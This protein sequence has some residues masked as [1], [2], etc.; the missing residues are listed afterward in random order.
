MFCFHLQIISLIERL[1]DCNMKIRQFLYVSKATSFLTELEKLIDLF[2]EHLTVNTLKEQE[3]QK[4]VPPL[5][6]ENQTGKFKDLEPFTY[7]VQLLTRE[8]LGH[9]DYLDCHSEIQLIV[10]HNVPEICNVTPSSSNQQLSNAEDQTGEESVLWNYGSMV[11]K[12]YSAEISNAIQ[13]LR[14]VIMSYGTAIDC[15][16]CGSHPHSN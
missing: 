16:R 7:V 2:T 15:K 10:R 3:I 12:K 11:P 5:P 4:Q 14:N 1:R 8:L 9:E 13:E 6:T